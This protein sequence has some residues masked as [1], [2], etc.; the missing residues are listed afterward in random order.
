MSDQPVIFK[1][2]KTKQ[3]PIQRARSTDDDKPD[4]ADVE[5]QGP[6]NLATK[7]KKRTK[8]KSKLSFGADDDVRCRA[9]RFD[10]PSNEDVREKE[11]EIFSRSKS[12]N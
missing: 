7:V 10:N 11:K 12:Q 6:M 2:N 8:L 4:Q 3:Q 9:F 1:R 5:S